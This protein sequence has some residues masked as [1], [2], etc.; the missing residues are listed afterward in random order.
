MDAMNQDEIPSPMVGDLYVDEN[1]EY[2]HII[3]IVNNGHGIACK[4]GSG[5]I[6]VSIDEIE[7][8]QTIDYPGYMI[9]TIKGMV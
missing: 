8:S 9:W 7:M 1:G 3:G 4:D 2:F 5:A 6:Y